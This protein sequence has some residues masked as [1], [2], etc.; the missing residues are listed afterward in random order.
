MSE[1]F[2]GLHSGHLP[3]SLTEPIEAE[4]AD[5]H[6]FH[7]NYIEQGRKRGWWSC[8]NRG[9]PFDSAVA[10]AVMARL[11]EMDD[12]EPPGDSPGDSGPAAREES[13][14][15]RQQLKDAGRGHLLG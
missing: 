9:E 14:S 12:E 1:H 15:Y 5:D 7:V 4:F 10:R 8:R 3:A 2:F 6:V 11:S 13:E